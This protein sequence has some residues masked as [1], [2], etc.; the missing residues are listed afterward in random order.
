[1]WQTLNW[2]TRCLVVPLCLLVL[3]EPASA[4]LLTNG[5]FESGTDGDA[6][7]WTQIA[8]HE[9]S[10]TA[11]A[12]RGERSPYAGDYHAWLRLSPAPDGAATAEFQQL[13]PTN[14]IVPG[15][16]Y[17]F[18]V[19]FSCPGMGTGVVG[20]IEVQWLDSDGSDGGGLKGSTG[21][22]NLD[23]GFYHPVGFDNAIAAPGSDSALV[24]MRV[25]SPPVD[26]T[27]ADLRFDNASLVL[28]PEPTG[29]AWVG[30]GILLLSRRQRRL[31][32]SR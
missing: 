15:Q 2:I 6:D 3:A 26:S 23:I 13:T 20:Q 31:P 9:G 25:M 16:P 7:G 8:T 17:D 21:A 11:S 18:E 12:I 1:M 4:N 32:A 29:L 5:G 22:L 28:V 24:I 10:S 19:Q 14:S 27:S 30:L